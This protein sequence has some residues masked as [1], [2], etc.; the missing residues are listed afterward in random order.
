MHRQGQ[1][2]GGVEH[3]L[4][5]RRVDAGRVQP[6]GREDAGER[7]EPDRETAISSRPSHHSGIE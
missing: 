5:R 1:V 6:A 4:E 2:P 3:A 7:P